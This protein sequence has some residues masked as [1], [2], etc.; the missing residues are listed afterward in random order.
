MALARL[1]RSFKNPAFRDAIMK[2]KDAPEI[3][4][5]IETEDAKY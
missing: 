2:A 5:L 3:Y 4:R 1:S